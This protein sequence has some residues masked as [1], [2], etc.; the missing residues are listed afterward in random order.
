MARSEPGH[1]RSGSRRTCLPSFHALRSKLGACH[2][3][4]ELILSYV[5]PDYSVRISGDRLIYSAAHFII[6]PNGEC[7]PLHGHNYRVAIE[8]RGPLDATGCVVDFGV[9][10]TIAKS[11]LAEIDHA[12]LLPAQSPRIRVSPGDSEVEVRFES[13]RWIFPARSAVCC[14]FRAR[15]WSSWR[16]IL[17]IAFWRGFRQEGCPR[18]L[19]CGSN[20]RNCPACA[21]VCEV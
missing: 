18:R 5:M 3:I 17:P 11:A 16:A 19:A 21:A 13:R 20:S 1:P 14:R 15:R 10:L 12:V 9:L 7:E 2:P 8:A 4:D 6:L